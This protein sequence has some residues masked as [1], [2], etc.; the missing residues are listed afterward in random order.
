MMMSSSSSSTFLV[1]LALC[2]IFNSCFSDDSFVQCLS[3]VTANPIPKDEVSRIVYDSG[4]ASFPSVLQAYLRNRRFNATSSPKPVAIVTPLR[5][6][7]VPPVVLCAKAIGVQLR[8]RSGGHDYEGLSYVSN[9]TFIILDMFNLRSI[10]VDIAGET[11]WVQGGATLGEFYYGIWEKSAEHGFPAAVCPTVGVG[12]HITGGGYGNMIRRYG[13]TSDH[14]VDARIV[15]VNGRIL[16]R[17]AM[18]EDLFWAIRGGGA[19][20]FGVILAYK[21]ELVKVPKSVT[22]FRAEKY[23]GQTE[24]FNDVISQYFNAASK[25]DDNLFIRLM[26]QVTTPPGSQNVTVRASFVGLFLGDSNTLISILNDQFPKLGL[27]LSDLTE[28]SWIQSV[29]T[30]ANFDNTTKPETLLNRTPGKSSFFRRKSDYLQKPFPK[31]SLTSL[32][33]KLLELGNTGLT[34][35]PYGGRMA[36]IPSTETPFPHRAGILFKIQYAVNWKEEGAA[37]DEKYSSQIRELH[38]FMT[39]FVSSN[40]RQAYINYRDID[41]GIN[42]HGAHSYEEGKV[43][44]ERYFVGNFERLVTVKSR[45]DPENFFRYEQSIPTRNQTLI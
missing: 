40:P 33:E 11:A 24:N 43:Y 20:S 14:V 6:S 7:H 29:L 21:I 25:T 44:G 32:C 4:N 8:I 1:F 15:D 13:L 22:Y 35:N 30:W 41:V 2:S 17:K 27:N 28:M 9:D 37:A 39:P 12:G 45:V 16:D 26:L 5:E 42:H 36:E 23:F 10:Q 19:A 34:F 31:E 3:N 38:S 18:G